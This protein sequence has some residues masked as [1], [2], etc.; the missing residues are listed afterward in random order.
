MPAK[1]VVPDGVTDLVVVDTFLNLIPTGQKV[2]P[3]SVFYDVKA[4]NR[5]TKGSDIPLDLSNWQIL[6]FLDALN[7]S[8][9]GLSRKKEAIPAMILITTVDS[10]PI[11]PNTVMR[12]TNRNIGVYHAIVCESQVPGKGGFFRVGNL[13]SKNPQVYNSRQVKPVKKAYG[14]PGNGDFFR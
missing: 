3:L 6:G 13:A 7:V 9:A 1:Q 10:D 2:Y 11:N 4:Y 5:T 12:A 14:F 8:A